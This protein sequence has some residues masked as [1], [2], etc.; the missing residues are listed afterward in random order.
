MRKMVG[1][2][3]DGEDDQSMV[4]GGQVRQRRPWCVKRVGMHEARKTGRLERSGW[5]IGG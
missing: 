5:E 1:I 4:G 2:T 3:A